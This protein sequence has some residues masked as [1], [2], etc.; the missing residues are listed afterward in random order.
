MID[1]RRLWRRGRRRGTAQ[2]V[3]VFGSPGFADDPEGLAAL[4][5]SHERLTGWMT[6]AGLDLEVSAAGLQSVDAMVDRWRDDPTIAPALSN[7]VGVFLG[8]VLLHEIRGSRWHVW[9]NGHPVVRL[10]GGREIDV[11]ARTESRVRKSQPHLSA[12][13]DGA[14]AATRHTPR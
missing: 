9:P 2:G 14:R 1:I 8:D 5:G 6:A 12:I 3:G 7:D 4:L 10:E 13:L 11:T